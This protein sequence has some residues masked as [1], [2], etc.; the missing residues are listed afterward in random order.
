MHTAARNA[1]AAL[2][3]A[4]FALAALLLGGCAS[5][6]P[7]EPGSVAGAAL[8]SASPAQAPTDG[9]IYAAGRETSFFEDPKARR[10][11]DLITIR[12][13]EATAASKSS[14]TDTA[15]QATVDLPAPTI[16]GRAVV[17][18]SGV[19]LL[20]TSI[21]GKRTFAGKGSSSQ[22]NQ[23][24]GSITAVVVEVLPNGNLVIEGEKWLRLNQ[25]DELVRVRGV[26]RPF[27]VLADNSVTSDRVADARIS[28]SGRGAL[29][30]ANR[31]GWL[32]R[33]FNSGLFP[34]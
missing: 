26:V 19:N 32:S 20:E 30:A 7:A 33:F 14:S 1:H 17:N 28:Y 5:L 2:L 3:L 6:E 12:L 24:T 23:L 25:G 15:K 11:G 4:L 8:R 34:Y 27:D 16:A 31:Q 22:Q 18:N 29:A 21:D 9:A 13:Q 10:K